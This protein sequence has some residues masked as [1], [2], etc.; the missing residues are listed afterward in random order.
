MPPRSYP[1]FL[2]DTNT[3]AR[4]ISSVGKSDGGSMTLPSNI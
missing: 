2:S 3:P 1:D 4:P